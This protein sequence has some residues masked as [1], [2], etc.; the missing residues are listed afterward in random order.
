[1][2]LFCRVLLVGSLLASCA[3]ADHGE[4]PRPT[5]ELGA[6][7]AQLRGGGMR[8]DVQLGRGM[9]KRPAKAGTIKVAPHAVVSP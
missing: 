2:S 3:S 7:A 5:R 4:A 9:T 6:G 1:M 8:M